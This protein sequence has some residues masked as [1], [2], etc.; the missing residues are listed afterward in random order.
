M[1]KRFGGG[2]DARPMFREI[3]VYAPKG[4]VQMSAHTDQP[5]KTA[6]FASDTVTVTVANSGTDAFQGN[7]GASA[8]DGWSISPDK[9]PVTV[10][11][12][13]KSD[14]TFTVKPPAELPVG[15]ARF[16]FDAQDAKGADVD[17]DVLSYIVTAPFGN[18][19]QDPLPGSR[20]RMSNRWCL[21]SSTR[22]N[23]PISGTVKVEL[24]GPAKVDPMEQPFGPLDPGKWAKPQF[25]LPIDLKK[26]PWIATYTCSV[27]HLTSKVVMNLAQ[28]QWSIIGPFEDDIEKVFGPETDITSDKVDTTRNYSD[29]FGGEQKWQVVTD[30]G[31][32]KV[33]LA[34]HFSN[35]S[36]ATAYAA[37]W[38]NSP[39]AQ[40]ARLFAALNRAGKIWVNGKLVIN[41][42]QGRGTSAGQD[43]GMVDLQQ[44]DNLILVKVVS[45]E[46]PKLEFSFDLLD[47]ATQKSLTDVTYSPQSS[48]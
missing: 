27:N 8:P 5:A 41:R 9:A 44:G 12:G 29:T 3:E 34:P 38:V 30:D 25:D 40:P 1:I 4:S 35:S 13:A 19:H 24:S 22:A 17:Y 2:I 47:P 16:D 46:Q 7:I 43:H 31:S 33:N 23:D 18:F 11:A 37:V 21:G 42:E 39:K 32:G 15:N 28:R 10:A 48:Q 45:D 20:R 14:V 36:N 26:G 6:A